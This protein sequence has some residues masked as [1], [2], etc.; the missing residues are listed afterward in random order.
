MKIQSHWWR[1]L[2]AWRESE[3]SQAEYCRIQGLNLKTFSKWL[4]RKIPTDQ[5]AQIDLI[6]VQVTPS[7]LVTTTEATVVLRFTCG[8]QLELSTAVS[9]RWL[10]QL[11]QCLVVC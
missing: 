11:L 4:R 8:A 2:D 3:L 5:N 7:E 10:A 1:H 9:P 6:P